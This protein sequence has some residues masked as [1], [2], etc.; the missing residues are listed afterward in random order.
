MFRLLL[1]L[2][3]LGKSLKSVCGFKPQ[4]PYLSKGD[5]AYLACCS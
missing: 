3:N 2:V 5:K 4:F 1:A